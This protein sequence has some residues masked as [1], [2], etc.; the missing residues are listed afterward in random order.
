MSG[1]DV[2]RPELTSLLSVLRQGDEV[3]V[4]EL[5]RLA[6]NTKDLL[7]VV[8]QVLNTGASIRFYKEN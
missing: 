3:H 5:S 1:K 2:N 6:R 4:H 7:S 8:E